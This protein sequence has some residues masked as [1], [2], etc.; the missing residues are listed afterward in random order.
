MS[1]PVHAVASAVVASTRAPSVRPASAAAASSAPPLPSGDSGNETVAPPHPAATNTKSAKIS[2]RRM[3]R[4]YE[5]DAGSA[6][7]SALEDGLWPSRDDQTPRF[8]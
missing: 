3:G 6:T 8:R 5:I 1:C 7:A 2:G 4:L